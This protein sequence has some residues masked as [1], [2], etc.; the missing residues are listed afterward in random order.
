MID[1]DSKP[2]ARPYWVVPVIVALVL[3]LGAGSVIAMRRARTAP[4][5]TAQAVA[6]ASALATPPAPTAEPT[7]PAPLAEKGNV[8]TVVLCY[9][10]IA[11]KPDQQT[12]LPPDKFAA[13]LQWLADNKYQ[14]LALRDV[15]KAMTDGTALPTRSVVITFDDGF[16]TDYKTAFPLLQKHQMPATVFV[17]T[18]W[19][20][21]A[22]GAV[23]WE[24][25]AEMQASGL[26]D[27]QS[28][29]LNHVDLVKTGRKGADQLKKELADSKAA[30]E[31]H[32]K[33]PCTI[34]AYPYGASNGAVRAATKAAGYEAG[35][36]VDGG[37]IA[38]GGDLFRLGRR[39]VFRKDSLEAFANQRVA[40]R[41]LL[42]TGQTPEPDARLTDHPATA[43]AQLPADLAQAKAFLTLDG[44]QIECRLDAATGTVS[45]DLPSN[46]AGKHKVGVTVVDGS[47]KLKTDWTF[48][49]PAAPKPAAKSGGKKGD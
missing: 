32:L 34:I 15:V 46:L 5:P 10:R 28:H 41:R 26:I 1:F 31:E 19:V 4:V 35:L 44:K 17:Y 43:S 39:M 38:T 21:K 7:P 12:V 3:G 29:T 18:N 13:Q 40:P 25:L 9:H 47:M 6:S 33:K 49:A 16:L 42:L 14:V 37:P 30:I 24:Q 20:G 36:T 22:A 27:V 2:A 8:S 45:G 11:D 48:S 23:K